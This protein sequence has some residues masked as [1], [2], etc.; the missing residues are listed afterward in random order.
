MLLPGPVLN[1][2]MGSVELCVT[3]HAR[4]MHML[5]GTCCMYLGLHAGVC[6]ELQCSKGFCCVTPPG[7][8]FQLGNGGSV[9]VHPMW[10]CYWAFIYYMLCTYM[11][12]MPCLAQPLHVLLS[13]G[14]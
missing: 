7:W 10:M 14:D 2:R 13:F 3:E 4:C 12:P 1:P 5:V 6:C 9:H 8:T 11:F